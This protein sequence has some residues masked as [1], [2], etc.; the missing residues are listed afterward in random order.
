MR[1][2][3]FMNA[4]RAVS[5]MSAAGPSSSSSAS[6]SSSVTAGGVWLMSSA[7]SITRRSSGVKTDA[8][9]QRGTS[10]DLRLVELVVVRHEVVEVEAEAA[11]DVRGRGHGGIR[12]EVAVELLPALDLAADAHRVLHHGLVVP[13]HAD[14]LGDLADHLA[15]GE[16]HDR[17]VQRQ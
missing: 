12:R 10:R 15:G 1:A 13:Q 14:R 11:A 17:A 2:L 5:S 7:Y 3:M 16:L 6:D 9:R 8:S 4:T